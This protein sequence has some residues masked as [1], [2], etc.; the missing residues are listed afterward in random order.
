VRSTKNSSNPFIMQP[1]LPLNHRKY[2]RK[3]RHTTRSTFLDHLERICT[4]VSEAAL[5]SVRSSPTSKVMSGYD[6]VACSK[7]PPRSSNTSDRMAG[8]W[9]ITEAYLSDTDHLGHT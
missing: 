3:S 5:N 2:K 8:N 4:M 9:T 6:A 7:T 1:E